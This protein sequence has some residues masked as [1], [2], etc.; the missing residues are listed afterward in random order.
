MVLKDLLD[1]ETN[2][3]CKKESGLMALVENKN[4][5][6]LTKLPPASYIKEVYGRDPKMHEKDINNIAHW[7]EQKIDLCR[8]LQLG[9]DV[10]SKT[11]F[12]TPQKS[13]NQ[14][15]SETENRDRLSSLESE[16]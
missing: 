9:K 16:F 3:F 4:A 8:D 7:Y 13:P 14:K 10:F 2:S 1:I 12:T 6:D 11:Y 15:P 5:I